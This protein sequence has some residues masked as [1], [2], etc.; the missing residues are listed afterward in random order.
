[1]NKFY[2]AVLILP[3]FIFISCGNDSKKNKTEDNKPKR[4]S[5]Y[6]KAERVKDSINKLPAVAM[7]FEQAFADTMQQEHNV[8]VEGYLQ[9]RL[10]SSASSGG[11]SMNFFGR[12]NQNH[13]QSMYTRIHTGTGNNRMKALPENY[14]LKDLVITDDKGKTFSANERVRITGR[15]K[16][17]FS[18]PKR[19]AVYLDVIKMERIPDAR[20]DYA[21]LNL[22]ELSFGDDDKEE[23]RDKAYFLEGKLSM[24]MYVLTG[25][26][27]SIDLTNKKGQKFTVKILNGKGISQMENLKEGWTEKD[28]VI[29]DSKGETVPLKKNV[30][31]YGVLKLDGL[32]VEEIISL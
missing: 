20:T 32:H 25:A 27:I 6:E 9:L 12:H 14:R 23:M 17:S 18:D 15:M 24:P 30:R 21:A 4:E 22:P 13:G 8:S 3:G 26:E 10:M 7:T 16:A 2:L 5:A 28:V 1:M 31:V 11:Q 19:K 29:R